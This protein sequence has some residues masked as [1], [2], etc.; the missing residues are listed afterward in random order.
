MS[1]L[2]QPAGHYLQS[3]SRAGLTRALTLAAGKSRVS[4]PPGRDWATRQA[5]YRTGPPG[6][7]LSIIQPAV[8]APGRTHWSTDACQCGPSQSDRLNVRQQAGQG[9][10][11]PGRWSQ[12]PAGGWPRR[13]RAWGP[14][15]LQGPC[16]TP[17]TGC[18][19]GASYYAPWKVTDKKDRQPKR[20]QWEWVVAG[21]RGWRSIMQLWQD[22]YLSVNVVINT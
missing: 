18:R 16:R 5:G 3:L 2:A 8:T 7:R 13:P 15:P 10:G 17:S 20:C 22:R 12:S 4:G 9:P 6:L 14:G 21:G 19:D 11:N 1:T